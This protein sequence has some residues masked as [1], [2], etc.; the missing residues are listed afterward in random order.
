MRIQNWKK[1]TASLLAASIILFALSGCGGK[2]TAE[3]P[4]KTGNP[5]AAAEQTTG[6]G[7]ENETRRHGCGCIG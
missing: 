1:G 4:A 2:K 5:P 3:A 6:A 7:R